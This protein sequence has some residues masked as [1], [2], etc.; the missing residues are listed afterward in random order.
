[1]TGV[2]SSK[3]YK[4]IK[5]KYILDLGYHKAGTTISL[6]S[7]NGESL[8][9]SAYMVD[10]AVLS[11]FID[12]LSNQTMTV[13]SFDDTHMEGHISV[14]NPG[15]LILSVPYEPGWTLLVDGKKAAIDLFEDAF[16]SVYLTEGEHTIYHS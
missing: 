11:E 3:D 9:L 2:E 12:L 15:Q 16:M 10:E 8:N 4:D 6:S 14:T 13:D 7:K 5:K 1:M